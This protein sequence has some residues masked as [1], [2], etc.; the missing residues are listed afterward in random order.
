MSINRWMN[1]EVVVHK[2]KG[3]FSLVQFSRSLVSNILRPHESQHTRPLCPSPTP[4]VHSNPLSIESVMPSDHLILCHPLLACPQSFPASGSFPMNQ[5]FTSGGQS[6]V[7]SASV[8]V[9]LLKGKLELKP[10]WDLGE[11]FL[12]VLFQ[13]VAGCSC[14]IMSDPCNVQLSHY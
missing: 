6:I 14:H 2:H 4:G 5:L 1:E 3:I 10:W 8:S 11:T 13:G 7:A 12:P 9:F